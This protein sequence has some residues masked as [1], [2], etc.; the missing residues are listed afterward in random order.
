[1]IAAGRCSA[2]K[3]AAGNFAAGCLGHRIK[4]WRIGIVKSLHPFKVNVD[5]F[6]S[7]DQALEWDKV[8]GTEDEAK[9]RRILPPHRGI[10]KSFKQRASIGIAT[11]SDAD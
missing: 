8:D 3:F 9:G 1:M 2:G 5:G 6:D 10:Q 7:L 11:T 4:K